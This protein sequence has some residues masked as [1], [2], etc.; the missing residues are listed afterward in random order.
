[1]NANTQEDVSRKSR[2]RI[3]ALMGFSTGAAGS[4]KTK[5]VVSTSSTVIKDETE[6]YESL[7]REAG[8]SI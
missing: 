4:K 2:E 8:G 1:M 5:K 3:S 6:S 7:V